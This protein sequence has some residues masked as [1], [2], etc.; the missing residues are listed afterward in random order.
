MASRLAATVFATGL[1]HVAAF[2]F[3]ADG[4]L[5]VA[6]AAFEDA[7]TDAVYRV[8]RAGDTVERRRRDQSIPDRGVEQ[9]R[10]G[11]LADLAPVGLELGSQEV[12]A[13]PRLRDLRAG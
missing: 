10:D 8:D 3:D 2:A 7:G 5:W 11:V 4:R 12:L 9:R 13:L 6:T 1:A